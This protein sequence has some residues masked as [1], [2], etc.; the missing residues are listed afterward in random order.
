MRLGKHADGK[1]ALLQRCMQSSL[2]M[3]VVLYSCSLE[4]SPPSHKSTRVQW[5]RAVADHRRAAPRMGGGEGGDGVQGGGERRDAGWGE[6][7]GGGGGG[8]GGDGVSPPVGGEGGHGAWA[9]DGGGEGA[10]VSADMAA[11]MSLVLR[12]EEA[13]VSVV[14]SQ[15]GIHPQVSQR[16]VERG[17]VAIE[18]VSARHIH[19]LAD[20]TAAEV[21]GCWDEE[22]GSRP[23]RVKRDLISVKR[24]LIS[25]KRDLISVKGGWYPYSALH[26]TTDYIRYV[27]D[28]YAHKST[29][30]IYIYIY[31]R[32]IYTIYIQYIYT[33]ENSKYTMYIYKIYVHTRALKIYD[34]Y[35]RYTFA[36]EDSRY[37]RY[38]H[39][40]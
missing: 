1:L 28:I 17:I 14:M 40:I 11:L 36:Q 27:H 21:L 4:P 16:C 19:R 34:I 7:D 8:E 3:R 15:R 2:P 31:I 5:E 39:T 22:V 26:Q 29:H 35:T 12:L 23:L 32:Y 30:Y 18:R 13:R 25:V 9:G 20:I 6:G 10:W 38:I 37:I 33:Q 24:D